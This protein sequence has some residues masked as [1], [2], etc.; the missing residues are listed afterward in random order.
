MG[1]SKKALKETKMFVDNLFINFNEN[2]LP[3]KIEDIV[4]EQQID[5]VYY[6]FEDD[7]SGV[8]VLN[9]DS[10]TI[11]VNQGQHNV[12]R[13]FTIAHE[14]GHFILHKDQGKMFMDKILFR[15]NSN[16]YSEKQEQLEKEANNFAANILMPEKIVKKL[17][18]ESIKDF[19]DDLSIQ[20]LAERFEVSASAMTYRLINLGLIDFNN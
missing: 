12:R 18:S 2:D 16:Q 9:D 15:K 1:P 14:L 3:V 5:L 20:K 7:I 6:T 11:G 8:L 10:T 4:K 19:Y 13:R 17:F